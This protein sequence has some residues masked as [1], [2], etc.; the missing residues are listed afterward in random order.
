MPAP[1]GT[2]AEQGS[3]QQ[4]GGRPTTTGMSYIAGTAAE[5]PETV[6]NLTSVGTL[7]TSETPKTAGTL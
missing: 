4:H 6:G 2:L 5:M 7:T 1:V 3:Q